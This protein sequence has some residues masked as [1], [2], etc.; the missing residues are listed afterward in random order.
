MKKQVQLLDD[1]T[2][3]VLSWQK[4]NRYEQFPS[5]LPLGIKDCLYI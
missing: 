2:T 4:K 3:V 1:N 5:A